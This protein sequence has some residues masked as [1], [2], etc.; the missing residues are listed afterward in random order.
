[1][2]TAMKQHG[3]HA[4]SGEEMRWGFENL[5]ITEDRIAELGLTGVIPPTHVTCSNHEG[6]PAIKL[7]RWDG[8]KWTIFTD[9]IPAMTDLVRPMVEADAAQYAKENGITPRDCDS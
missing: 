2:S 6:S 5:D 3:N 7:Q 8:E 1:M 9:W 4:L